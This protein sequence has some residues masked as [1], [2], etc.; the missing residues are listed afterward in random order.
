MKKDQ[1]RVNK[2]LHSAAARRKLLIA[3]HRGSATQGN[4]IENTVPAFQCG[5][6]QHADILELDVVASADGKLFVFHD[7]PDGKNEMR[8]LGVQREMRTMTAAEIEACRYINHEGVPTA[9]RVNT[10]DEVLEA[11]KGKCLLNVDRSWWFWDLVIPAIQRHHMLDQCIV[12][13]EPEDKYLDYMEQ[14]DLPVMYSPKA[15]TEADVE[16]ILRRNLNVVSC[17]MIFFSEEGDMLRPDIQRRLHD[18]GVLCWCNSLCLRDDWNR[19][20]W[21]NDNRAIT[22]DPDGNWGWLADHGFDIIQTD[23]PGLL[24]DYLTA[25]GRRG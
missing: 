6:L 10:F 15:Y 1:D 19:S 12:K 9:Q 24:H 11:M 22:G 16:N 8:L 13:S 5:L 3:S 25:T 4:I 18:R 21:R 23:W 7:N 17:E 2:R 14:M 20:A